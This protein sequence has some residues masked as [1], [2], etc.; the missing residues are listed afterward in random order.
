MTFEGVDVG[1]TCKCVTVHGC[2]GFLIT[3]C[4]MPSCL[5]P[6]VN[7]APIE[8]EIKAESALESGGSQREKDDGFTSGLNAFSLYMWLIYHQHRQKVYVNI[9]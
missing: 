5:H 6:H 7:N 4:G 2:V 8:G 3:R 9:A 1:V